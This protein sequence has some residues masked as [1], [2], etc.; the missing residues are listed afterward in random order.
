LK[1]AALLPLPALLSQTLVAFTIEF[2]NE[3][4]H[5]SPHRTAASRWTEE[6]RHSPW[7]SSMVMYLNL[8]QYVPESGISLSELKRLARIP[9]PSINGMRRWGYIKVAEDRTI[10]PTRAGLA[11]QKVWTSLF[12][13]IEKRWQE[14]FGE[15]AIAKLRQSLWALAGRIDLDLPAYLPVVGYGLT[16][17][18]QPANRR[19][20]LTEPVHL[21]TLLSQVLLAFT[22]E[23][24]RR[25][26]V[27]LAIGANV[28]RLLGN[29]EVRV[30][31][32]PR[33]SG[34]S[35]EAIAMAVG[36]LVRRGFMTVE[37]PE[38][39]VLLTQKGVKAKNEY[40][41]LLQ[42]IEADWQA[43]FGMPAIRALRESLEGLQSKLLLGLEP[44]PGGWRAKARKPETLPHY[45]MVLHRGGY[46]DGS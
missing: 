3:L 29:E 42:A 19:V 43:R 24:E 6:L 22:I 28:L 10:R 11:A 36:F 27:S 21:V 1:A 31:D 16:A 8:L 39:I 32:L 35:K 23:F 14:R 46:P 34:V 7:L 44:Y 40:F 45:P 15:E 5:R 17:P 25:A 33:L 41:H 12:E 20:P 2:D 30:R 13:V 9:K 18:L 38:K 37:P 26:D 4:E